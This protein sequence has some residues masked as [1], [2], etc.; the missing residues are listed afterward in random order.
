MSVN[1]YITRNL[2]RVADTGQE[3]APEPL[4]EN[5]CGND[6]PIFGKLDGKQLADRKLTL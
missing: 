1:N 5:V 3:S 2:A 4:D 6:Y